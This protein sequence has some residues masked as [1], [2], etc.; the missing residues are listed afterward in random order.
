MKSRSKLNDVKNT[1]E[2][3]RNRFKLSAWIWVFDGVIMS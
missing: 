2:R 1:P 3:H